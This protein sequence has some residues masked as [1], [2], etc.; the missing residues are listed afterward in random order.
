MTRPSDI[1]P[2]EGSLP[3]TPYSAFVEGSKLG[4]ITFEITPAIV[5]EYF[6][7]S[8]ADPDLYKIDGRQAAAPNVILPYMTVPVYQNYPPIQ[9][10]VMAELEMSWHRPIWADETTSITATGTILNKFEKRGR[11]YIQWEGVFSGPDGQ[12]VATLLN[13]FHVPE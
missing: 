8:Q 11:R 9:G 7:A 10:I 1:K 2:R 3:G 5:E 13:T 6:Q 12:A 4:P